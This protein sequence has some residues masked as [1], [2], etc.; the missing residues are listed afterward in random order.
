MA[1]RTLPTLTLFSILL[2]NYIVHTG[3][4]DFLLWSVYISGL[5]LA[6]YTIFSQPGGIMGY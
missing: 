6:V 1:I 5:V 4:F 3:Q 2:Y